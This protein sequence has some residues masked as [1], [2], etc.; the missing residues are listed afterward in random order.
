MKR[1]LAVTTLL[2]ASAALAVEVYYLRPKET[3]SGVL[4][5]KGYSKIYGKKGALRELIELNPKLKKSYGNKVYPGMKILLPPLKIEPNPSVEPPQV[6]KK[7]EDSK[8]SS[9]FE[10]LSWG[11]ELSLL[12]V[13]LRSNEM[14]GK[15]S[16][17]SSKSAFG[18]TLQIGKRFSENL[19]GFVQFDL[20]AVEFLRPKAQNATLQNAKTNLLTF[21]A[22]I[23][24]QLFSRLRVNSFYSL[25][26]SAFLASKD[27]FNF[28]VDQFRTHRLGAGANWSMLKGRSWDIYSRGSAAYAFPA[29]EG[30]LS[31]KGSLSYQS[32]IGYKKNFSHSALWLEGIYRTIDL[33]TTRASFIQTDTGV[34]AGFNLNFDN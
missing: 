26:E 5:S 31:S 14:S 11:L 8:K 16:E 19:Q 7:S 3:L 32:G 18:Q 30:N 23:D 9:F 34:L 29:S 33:K 20:L 4:F 2:A 17:L 27:G 25:A 10:N 6:I 15:K 12:S 22:G 24:Y 13:N 1:F 21:N 28:E